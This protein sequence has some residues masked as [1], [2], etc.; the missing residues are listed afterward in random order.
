MSEPTLITPVDAGRTRFGEVPRYR[1]G[2]YDLGYGIYA[3]LVPN[4]SWGESN[5]GL[6]TGDGASLLVDTLWDLKYTGAMLE[7]MRPLTESAP[8]Q[9]VVNT[10]AD[11]DHWW[12][13]QLLAGR[14]IITSQAAYEEMHHLQPAAMVLLGRVGRLLSSLRLFGADK[15]GRWFRNMVAPYDSGGVTP[16]LP[17][18]TFSG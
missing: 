18:R 5:A 1:E 12:G 15:V 16:A 8:I 11:S 17:T 2:L 14:E 9:I 10:H 3:W 6:I 13:N 4:G 7:A